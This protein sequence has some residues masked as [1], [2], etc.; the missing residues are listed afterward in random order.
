MR[1]LAL[2]T[3]CSTIAIMLLSTVPAVKEGMDAGRV[4]GRVER[5]GGGGGNIV[6]LSGYLY[7]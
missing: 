1:R 6:Q 2:I 5:K 7:I 4:P 3:M